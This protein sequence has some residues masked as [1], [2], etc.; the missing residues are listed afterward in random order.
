MRPIASL[1]PPGFI[2]ADR[3]LFIVSFFSQLIDNAAIDERRGVGIGRFGR[4]F[5]DRFERRSD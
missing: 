4:I 5:L 3:R 2:D 1:N